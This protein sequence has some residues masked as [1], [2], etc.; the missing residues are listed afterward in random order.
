MELWEWTCAACGGV[1]SAGCRLNASAYHELSP[2]NCRSLDSPM[3][4]RMGGPI[5]A[6]CVASFVAMSDSMTASMV[7]AVV[8]LRHECF[9]IFKLPMGL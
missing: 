4:P 8:N 5:T 1:D 2:S 9:R 6:G 7:S 3:L